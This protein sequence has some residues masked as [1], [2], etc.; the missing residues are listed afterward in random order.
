[1][2]RGATAAEGYDAARAVIDEL[3]GLGVDY[4]EVV[5]LLEAEAVT[6]FEEAWDA[7]ITQVD[8]KLAEATAALPPRP[9][10]SAP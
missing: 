6:K 9:A 4:D 1:M 8:A 10:P 5:D 3:A 2:I 7:F